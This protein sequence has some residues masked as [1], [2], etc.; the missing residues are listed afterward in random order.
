ML[1]KSVKTFFEIVRDVC[2]WAG[3]CGLPGLPSGGFG[4]A[5]AIGSAPFY[6]DPAGQRPTGA[7]G[8]S[9]STARK[10]GAGKDEL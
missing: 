7:F 10:S 2:G 1:A 5:L 6:G 4:A 9:I 3:G 8:C